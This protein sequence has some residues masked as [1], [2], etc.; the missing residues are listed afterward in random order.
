MFGLSYHGCF[1]RPVVVYVVLLHLAL[2]FLLLEFIMTM[3]V[4]LSSFFYLFCHVLRALFSVGS[5]YF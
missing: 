1:K 3:V 2:L 5:D 4:P